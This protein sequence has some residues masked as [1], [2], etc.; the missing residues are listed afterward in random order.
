MDAHSLYYATDEGKAGVDVL[1]LTTR[2]AEALRVVGSAVAWKREQD[3]QQ[4]EREAK[5]KGGGR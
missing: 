5:A 1:S 4:R 3:Q 2:Q